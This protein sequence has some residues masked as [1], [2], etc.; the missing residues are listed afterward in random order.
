MFYTLK[1][2]T[3]FMHVS[4]IEG[5]VKLTWWNTRHCHQ[6]LIYLSN[7]LRTYAIFNYILSLKNIFFTI[8]CMNFK[9][10][11]HV[12]IGSELPFCYF[13]LRIIITSAWLIDGV[14]DRWAML[15]FWMGLNHD[16][17]HLKPHI[18][19]QEWHRSRKKVRSESKCPVRGPMF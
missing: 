9:C 19:P 17:W 12:I 6:S 11:R 10:F 1:C 5:T 14:T 7:K 18:W 13:K 8:I 2:Y 3:I 16:T 4:V 15:V